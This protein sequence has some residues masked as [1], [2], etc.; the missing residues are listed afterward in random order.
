MIKILNKITPIFAITLFITS[1][2]GGG[3]GGGGD[4]TPPVTPAAT[5]SISLSSEKGYV[6]ETVT[7][8]WSSTNATSCTAS[9]AWTGTKGTSGSEAF[10]LNGAGSFAFEISCSGSG[11][12]GSASASF[13][14]FQYDKQT[15]DV[16]NKNWD[17]EAYATIT[18][19]ITSGNGFVT[20]VTASSST[21]LL[22]VNA[23]EPSSSSFELDY[24]GSSADGEQFDFN[25]VFNDWNTSTTLL[26]D[27]DDLS[28]AAYAFIRATYADAVVDGFLTLPDYFS[29]QGIDYVSAALVE[30]FTN[31]SYYVIPT[32]VGEFTKTD[33]LPSSGTSSKTFDTLGYYYEASVEAGNIYNGYIVADGQ[34]TLDFDFSN[35][36][37]S[38]S[39][40]YDTFVPYTSFKAGTG[41]YN[42][43]TSIPDQTIN[44]QNGTISGNSFSAEIVIN[45]GD[46]IGGG[47]INGHFYGP[48][49]DEIAVNLILLDNDENANDY[50]IFTAGGIGQTQ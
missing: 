39:F 21:G 31:P 38:G 6:G 4:S 23:F 34:G 43:I 41:A 44:L 33:D 19:G 45:N 25:L 46:T 13:Q 42:L 29:T 20:R 11:G 22:T 10:S 24:S 26:Y 16:I 35:N 17:A 37:V 50:F 30:I 28:N 18:E 49:A 47:T 7:V 3:G 1:C 40:T 2:G 27:P 5:S 8:T 12:S 48:N 32:N 36:T 14:V 9:N 15:D